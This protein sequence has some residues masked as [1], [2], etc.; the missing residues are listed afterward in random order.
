MKVYVAYYYFSGGTCR[1]GGYRPCECYQLMGI[2]SNYE[3]AFESFREKYDYYMECGNAKC[4]EAYV[5]EYGVI[6]ELTLDEVLNRDE[7]TIY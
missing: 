4:Y 2:F 5:D 7:L 1:D 3:K 6:E